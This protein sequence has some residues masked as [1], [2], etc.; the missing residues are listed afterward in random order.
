M[1]KIEKINRKINNYLFDHYRLKQVLHETK[2]ALCAILAAFIFA[3]GYSCFIAPYI[4]GGYATLE[5][6][7]LAKGVAVSELTQGVDFTFPF[8][9]IITGGVS[10]LSQTL[11]LILQ[12][13]GIYLDHSIIEGIGYTCFNIPILIFAFFKVGKRFSIQTAIN[14]VASSLFISFLVPAL[15]LPQMIAGNEWLMKSA[16]PMRLLFAGCCTG[17]S[18]AIAFR[19]ELSCGGIDVITYYYAMRKSTSVGKYGTIVNSV[20]ICTYSVLMVINPNGTHDWAQALISVLYS[21]VYLFVVAL[22]VDM[23]NLR[24]KKV[25]LEF[26]TENENLGEIL[27]SNFPHGATMDK[28]TG[29]YSGRE[30]YIFWMVVSTLE[31]NKVIA[32]ARKA[33]PK[34]FVTVTSLVQVYGNF[35][36]KPV[37]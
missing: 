29:V 36:I 15:K 23:I 16:A 31:A 1:K 33:E 19:G 22:V 3:F 11:N 37:E 28:A 12:M 18:S 13:C 5:D 2:G 25:Q 26:I 35:F 4:A 34:C 8:F 9:H 17:L 10:G 21:V 30:K 20:I 27:I 32:L 24:N 6:A 7:A 14:V